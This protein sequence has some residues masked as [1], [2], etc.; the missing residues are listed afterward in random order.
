MALPHIRWL[1]DTGQTRKT[2]DGRTVELWVLD[3]VDD[4]A[5]LSIWAKHFRE[6]YCSD[7]DLVEEAKGTG[8]T[9]PEF[10]RRMKFPS[11]SKGTG[12]ATR[13]G[14][15]GEILIADFMEFVCGLWCPRHVRYQ[16]RFNPDVPTPG[17]DVMAFKFAVE[18]D[19]SPNDELHIVETKSSLRSTKQN[20]LQD[21]IDDSIK[22][23]MREAVTLAALK[24]RLRKINLVDAAKVE[25]FQNGADRPFKRASAAATILDD[26]VLA[27]TDLTAVDASNHPNG[28][29]LRLIVVSGASLMELVT[30]LYDRAANEA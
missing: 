23:M 28:N 15:F 21:A 16:G 26:E 1:R 29:N 13:S 18:D 4:P 20:R 3:H 27:E 30:A 19:I 8:L 11:A 2:I 25:R 10:L 5:I 12:P 22:D 6:H 9:K 17:C 7:A 24:Q 14:D